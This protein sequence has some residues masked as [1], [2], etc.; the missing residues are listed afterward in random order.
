MSNNYRFFFRPRRRCYQVPLFM[1]L[2]NYENKQDVT[3][4]EK[5][6]S[7]HK[8]D[9]TNLNLYKEYL[10][11]IK[12]YNLKILEL[13]DYY[14]KNPIHRIDDEF[15]E[16]FY[17]YSNKC[18]TYLEKT[19]YHKEDINNNTVYEN[20]LDDNYMFDPFTIMETH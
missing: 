11:K 12:I 17:Q 18:I 3:N 1:T 4:T 2:H 15:C 8:I 13:T 9:N 19:C 5:N 7:I 6:K 20:N 10:S 14:L 16:A